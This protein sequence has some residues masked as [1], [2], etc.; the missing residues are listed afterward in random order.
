MSLVVT[1][2]GENLL[3]EWSV[4]STGE[5]LKLNLY[6]NNYTPVSTST[7]SNFTVASFTGY[8]EKTIARTDWGS[9]STNGNDKGEITATALSWT[10]TTT[11][12]IYGYFVTP[13]SDSTKVLWAEKFSTSVSLSNGD[14]FVLNPKLTF[15]SEA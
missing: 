1:D 15:A 12:T 10:P 9:A 11:Q 6:S 2:A 14:T 5:S 4:K 7:D 8:A 3:L 13:S